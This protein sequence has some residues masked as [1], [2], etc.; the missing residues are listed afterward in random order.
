MLTLPPDAICLLSPE[1][2]GETLTGPDAGDGSSSLAYTDQTEPHAHP[3][4]CPRSSG[5]LVM[6]LYSGQ[7]Y[8][9]RCRSSQC[10]VCL[11]LNARRRCLA[12]TYAKPRRMIRLSLLAGERDDNPCAT[13]LTRV[14]LIRR[15]LKRMGREP[16]EWSFT[17]ERNPKETG[18]H[19]HCLQHG[20][21]I[22]QAELQDACVRAGAGFPHINSIK[23]EG[24]WTS[25]Y[26]LKGF[27][28]D[29]YGLK[30]FRPNGNPTDALRINHGRLEH[31]SRR[32]FTIDGEPFRVREMERQA[33]AAM[34]GTNRVAYVGTSE[35]GYQYLLANAQARH[36]LISEIHR[37]DARK[38]RAMA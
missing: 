36:A 37:R 13:A 14:G 19:A 7:G 2:A 22:P 10:G 17:I 31:H 29:G 8:P 38:L 16:G 4:R 9:D 15:N 24:V 27:G 32:F 3:L 26:G 25:R 30:G 21:S 1:T 35:H 20:P 12:I 23:R 34:N 11:P 28:A 5:R 6:E 33:I 18:Y